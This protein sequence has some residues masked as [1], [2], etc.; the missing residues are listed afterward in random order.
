MLLQQGRVQVRFDDRTPCSG[1]NSEP[2]DLTFSKLN[3]GPI[4]RLEA[5]KVEIIHGSVSRNRPVDA[6][7]PHDV[8]STLDVVSATMEPAP[9]MLPTILH[10]VQPYSRH[11]HTVISSTATMVSMSVSRSVKDC[12]ESCSAGR[13]SGGRFACQ[14]ASR[15]AH[16]RGRPQEPPRP[17]RHHRHDKR[18]Q[19]ITLTHTTA[20]L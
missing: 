17:A 9:T 14:S 2:T 20:G 7:I 1:V 13:P 12:D 11:F 3:G 5:A 15:A 6:L 8:R 10:P 4:L 16:D 18:H 19:S